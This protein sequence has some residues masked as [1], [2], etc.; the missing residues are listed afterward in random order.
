MSRYKDA[1]TKVFNLLARAEATASST[2]KIGWYTSDIAEAIEEVEGAVLGII[3]DHWPQIDGDVDD[4]TWL[5][6]VCGWDS[7]V[8]GVDDWHQHLVN[9]VDDARWEGVER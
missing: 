9:A 7:S 4:S 1:R 8:K 5:T 2:G 3:E 6:C